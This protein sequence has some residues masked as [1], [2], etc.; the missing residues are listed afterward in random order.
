MIF[1]QTE[2]WGGQEC[3]SHTFEEDNSLPARFDR[4]DAANPQ[5]YE[6]LVSLA[7]S[8]RSKR[9]DSTI[10]IGML[11]EVLRWRC[12]ME[13]DTEEP[14]RLSNDFRAFY[15]RKIMRNEPDLGGI[16]QTKKSVADNSE[17]AGQ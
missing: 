9:P 11:Y 1:E 13:T 7:R 4:F 10:G 3:P 14:Y 5:V 8:I 2:M 17:E 15:A 12:Y 16:F 6:A